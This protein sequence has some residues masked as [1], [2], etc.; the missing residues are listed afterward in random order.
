MITS[1]PSVTFLGKM[2]TG[3]ESKQCLWDENAEERGQ[4]FIF[5]RFGAFLQS[6]EFEKKFEIIS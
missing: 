6:F 1:A 2:K 3:L 4:R 5:L